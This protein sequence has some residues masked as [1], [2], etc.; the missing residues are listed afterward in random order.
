MA[1]IQT[2]NRTL[3]LFRKE[4][5][6]W[7][8]N[9]CGNYMVYNL[10]NNRI[11]VQAEIRAKALIEKYGWQLTAKASKFPFSTLVIGTGEHHQHYSAIEKTEIRVPGNPAG[12]EAIRQSLERG[13]DA[14]QAANNNLNNKCLDS[15]AKKSNQ[16]KVSQFELD[17]DMVIAEHGRLC[18][19]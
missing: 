9:C 11:A 14:Y 17:T 12:Y 5:G 15:E 3:E 19:V 4:F 2:T 13:K 6:I 8:V 7:N 18:H 10:T 16:F 1:N